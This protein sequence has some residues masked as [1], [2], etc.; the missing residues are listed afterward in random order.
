MLLRQQ[1]ISFLPIICRA[2]KHDKIQHI[3]LFCV[4]NALSPFADIQ[5]RDYHGFNRISMQSVICFGKDTLDIPMFKQRVIFR[6]TQPLILSDYI[7][8]ECRA[9]P[10]PEIK[11]YVFVRVSSSSISSGLRNNSYCIGSFYPL[12]RRKSKGVK[13]CLTSKGIE[14]GAFK[15]WIVELFPYTEIFDGG[16]VSHPILYYVV[17]SLCVF[18]SRHV[19]KADVILFVTFKHDSYLRGFYCYCFLCHLCHDHL[20]TSAPGSVSN[21]VT[22]CEPTSEAELNIFPE[23]VTNHAHKNNN[24]TLVM[25]AK[26]LPGRKDS[27]GNQL[28]ESLPRRTGSARRSFSNRSF[29]RSSLWSSSFSFAPL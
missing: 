18:I 28:S 1:R 19:C 27:D 3:R 2:S 7:Q 21:K 20:K 12:F 25:Q 15:I 5:F 14:F 24:K 17:C 22:L 9:E 10:H 6:L 16:A 29:S 13:A 4:F 26:L 23:S 11:S 8:L